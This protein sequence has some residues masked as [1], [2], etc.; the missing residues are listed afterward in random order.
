MVWR[1]AKLIKKSGTCTTFWFKIRTL[2]HV[3]NQKSTISYLL[4]PSKLWSC[5][6]PRK[7]SLHH[8]GCLRIAGVYAGI[9]PAHR[10][11][12]GGTARSKHGPSVL[13]PKILAE[14][15]RSDRSIY[16]ETCSKFLFRPGR[17][18]LG[19]SILYSSRLAVFARSVRK[20]VCCGIWI[21]ASE[22]GP[23]A[24]HSERRGRK[25]GGISAH[26][27]SILTSVR[28]ISRQR[29]SVF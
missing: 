4:R 22:N 12:L 29:F 7:R 24:Y 17:F 2:Y 28:N 1:A 10:R 27:L 21:E 5:P 13:R 14:R 16:V 9:Y 3:Q 18:S 19:T 23:R 20:Y 15:R 25:L 26:N 11:I 8:W 6:N